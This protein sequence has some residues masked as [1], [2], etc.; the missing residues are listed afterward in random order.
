VSSG[1]NVEVGGRVS[2]GIN[3]EVGG[4]VSS[5]MILLEEGT[6]DGFFI[7]VVNLGCFLKCGDFF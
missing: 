2:S 5:G 3:V 6:S 1:I 7:A 4:R